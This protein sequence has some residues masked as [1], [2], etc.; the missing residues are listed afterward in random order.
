MCLMAKLEF[1]EEA[2]KTL[3]LEF[4]SFH[5]ID[6]YDLCLNPVKESGGQ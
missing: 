3:L 4:A 6:L 2:S 5:L 1:S